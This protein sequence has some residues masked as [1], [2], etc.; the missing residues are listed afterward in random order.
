M[1]K[2]T[3]FLKYEFN[4][5]DEQSTAAKVAPRRAGFSLFDVACQISCMT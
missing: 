3:S 4:L 1:R 5:K 2:A